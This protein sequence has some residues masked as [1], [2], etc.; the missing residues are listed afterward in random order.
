MALESICAMIVR[1]FHGKPS[2]EAANDSA[3]AGGMHEGGGMR[4][5]NAATVA[6][7]VTGSIAAYKAAYLCRM[8]REDGLQVRV[9]MTPAA[10]SF[11]GAATFRALSGY[12]VITGDGLTDDAAAKDGMDHIHITRRASLLL[13][14]P[15]SAD[16]I[17]K[18]AAGFAD[19][20]LLAAFLAAAP[21][22]CPKMLAPAMNRQMWHSAPTQRNIQ[23]LAADGTT[24]IGPA[25]GEQACG[26][27]GEGRMT[28]PADMIK[29]VRLALHKPMRGL[30]VVVSTGATAENIDTMRTISNKSSGRMGFA[31]AAACRQAGAQVRVI[32]A[33]TSAPPPPSLP[34]DAIVRA[35]NNDLM[36]RALLKE[37]A[38]GQMFI[39]AAAVADYTSGGGQKHKHPRSGGKGLVIKLM[40]TNDILATIGKRYP[41][42]FTVGFAALD[43]DNA[44]GGKWRT[45]AKA[46]MRAKNTAM[47]VANSVN[48]ADSES[49]Q[50][51]VFYSDGGEYRL[52]RQ[53][54]TDAAA[55]LAVMLAERL[56]VSRETSA[57]AESTTK[58]KRAAAR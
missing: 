51:A 7:G 11:V 9:L 18:A 56:N 25:S 16:F 6:L 54:K 49:C 53:S 38:D 26:E 21:D 47:M 34:P 30:R 17:A 24:I 22:G 1:M 39:S 42:L 58:A 10:Q 14:A 52:P 44:D 43:G 57:A 46:K 36:E 20:G 41:H 5:N 27:K 3:A 45:A 13:I 55:S 50:L 12:P 2:A 40:P 15:A 31:I 28:E 19:N 37:C 8:L 35:A 23:T 4:D 29:A 48:D 32:A 33:N